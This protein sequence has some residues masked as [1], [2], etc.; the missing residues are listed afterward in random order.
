[1][2]TRSDVEVGH[3][4]MIACH[5]GNIA[6]RTGRRVA[7][8]VDKEQ[9]TGDAD[10]LL[11]HVIG[12][13]ANNAINYT[14]SGEVAV[15]LVRTD[16]MLRFSVKDSGVGLTE[17]DKAV[18]FTEGG[19]GK[20][21]RAVNPHSTGYGLFIAKRIVEAHKGRIYAESEGR[22][23]GSTFIVELPVLSPKDFGK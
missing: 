3:N 10:Q 13:L 16:G 6:Y 20:E 8:D 4:S 17:D 9:V 19:H 1:M 11:N 7:W 14:P 12:N 2:P 21:S 15:K 23:K 22:G 5:L 18:L